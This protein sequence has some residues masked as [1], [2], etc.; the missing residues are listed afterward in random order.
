[1]FYLGDRVMHIKNNYTKG[2]FNGNVGYIIDVGYKVVDPDKTDLPSYYAVV[3]FESSLL[4]GAKGNR[5]FFIFCRSISRKLQGS[6]R[7]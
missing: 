4:P 1:M 3:E 2:V 6:R 7:H 5:W